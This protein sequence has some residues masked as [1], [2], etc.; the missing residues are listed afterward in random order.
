MLLIGL[1]VRDVGVGSGLPL[2]GES[3]L[4]DGGCPGI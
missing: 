3:D 2:L 4:W 1:G